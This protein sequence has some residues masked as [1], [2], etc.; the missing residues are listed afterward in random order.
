MILKYHIIPTCILTCYHEFIA[1][2]ALQVEI[3]NFR[4]ILQNLND[5]KRKSRQMGDM[6]ISWSSILLLHCALFLSIS[7]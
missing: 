7:S 6:H 1:C 3:N 2:H 4:K 5:N